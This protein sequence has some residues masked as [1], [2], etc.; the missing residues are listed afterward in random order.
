MVKDNTFTKLQQRLLP[1][2]L[3]FFYIFFNCLGICEA[4]IGFSKD[5][6]SII[7]KYAVESDMM[8][9]EAMFNNLEQS[10][11]SFE[12]M[13]KASIDLANAIEMVRSIAY[14]ERLK[15]MLRKKMQEYYDEI[16]AQRKEAMNDVINDKTGNEGKKFQALAR[17]F[18][19]VN[20]DFMKQFEPQA[21]SM[22]RISVQTIG[23]KNV[24][25]QSPLRKQ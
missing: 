6:H 25:R 3:S 18:R 20:K 10:R 14:K 22:I 13:E 17:E 4:G 11:K 21:G 15:A 19:K 5:F 7:S 23:D 24:K 1:F 12:A 8:L 9:V 2:I 16:M